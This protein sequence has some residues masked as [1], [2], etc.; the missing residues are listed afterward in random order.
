MDLYLQHKRKR[1]PEE[2]EKGKETLEQE[3][4]GQEDEELDL[5]EVP[6]AVR[7]QELRELTKLRYVMRRQRK[8]NPTTLWQKALRWYI[9][10]VLDPTMT[11]LCFWLP[12]IYKVRL[13]STS[14]QLTIDNCRKERHRKLSYAV[15]E[16]DTWPYMF[17]DPKARRRAGIAWKNYANSLVDEWNSS[18]VITALILSAAV[19]FLAVPDINNV[20]RYSL[21]VT[22]LS[23]LAS[24][25]HA[26][27]H[28]HY[29]RN[30]LDDRHYNLLQLRCYLSC[31]RPI[32]GYL[33]CQPLLNLF[34]ALGAFSVGI[35]AYLWPVDLSTVDGPV[36][37]PPLAAKIAIPILYA[38]QLGLIGAS[39]KWNRSAFF[40]T[41][42]L[43]VGEE[44]R[45]TKVMEDEEKRGERM[46]EIIE[47]DEEMARSVPIVNELD[48]KVR[49]ICNI[50]T[51]L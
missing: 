41:N 37:K 48:E 32:N 26:S 43:L 4:N 21:I 17:T 24:L 33:L 20:S 18:N 10:P 11:A 30:I 44:G 29:Y 51:R 46:L 38:G 5:D 6:P 47:R 3:D 9:Y 7:Y 25:A 39:Y 14:I 16:P 27:Y 23:S 19:S 40:T 50:F 34:W 2:D 35:V 36:W 45:R 12:E 22:L 49:M 1:K 8:A 31:Y 28:A 42:E 15:L 13:Y